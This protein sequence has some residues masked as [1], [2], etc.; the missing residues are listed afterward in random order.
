MPISVRF[1]LWPPRRGKTYS[2]PHPLRVNI[3]VDGIEDPGFGALWPLDGTGEKLMVD[4]AKWRVKEQ[5]TTLRDDSTNDSLVL[6]KAHIMDIYRRQRQTGPPTTQSIRHE[7]TTGR[8]PLW[9]EPDGWQ[10]HAGQHRE[11]KLET[12]QPAAPASYFAA[13]LTEDTDL[14]EAYAAY[15]IGLRLK[16]G[17]AAA[18]SPI[19]IG[20][21]DRGMLLLQLWREQTDQPLPAV[22]KVTVGWAK[23][24]H[25]WLQVISENDQK[26]KPTSMTQASRFVLKIGEV[27]TW[28]LDEGWL[29]A[30]PIAA[31]KWPRAKDK[32]VRFLTPDQLKKL[33]QTNWKGTEGDAL[34]WFCLMCC[35][36][37]DYPDAIAYARSRSTYE[38][39]GPSGWKIVGRRAKP[40]YNQYEVP[41]LDEVRLL[42]ESRPAGPVDYS[43]QCVNR[44]TG[45]IEQLLGIK[46]RITAKT[47]RKTFTCLMLMKGYMSSEVAGMLGHSSTRTTDRYYY[48]INGAH[49]DAGMKRVNGR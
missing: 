47:A 32:E 5:K 38:T 22:G 12:H 33:F 48:R 45:R 27:L 24:Y 29:V 31:V 19:T 49:V 15:V 4:P 20:R 40:P 10:F 44:H 6:L 11:K 46:W 43:P 14:G 36:G 37:L 26:I 28:M 34:W 16:K 42:F 17:T 25:A 39:E 30:N 9:L 41:L 8:P 21:W 7:L 1:R 35:T 18:L 3:T 13:Q 2:N 23:R